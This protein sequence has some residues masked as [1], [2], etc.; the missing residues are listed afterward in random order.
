MFDLAIFTALGWERQ[1]VTQALFALEPGPEPGTWRGRLGDGASCVVAQTGMG[2][3][4]ARTAAAALPPAR[5]FLACGCA[6]GLAEWLQAGDLVVAEHVDVVDAEGGT[7]GRLDAHGGALTSWAAGRG[8]RTHQGAVV[9]TLTA[10]HTAD[11][12]N[13][14]GAAGALVVEMES[15]AVAAEARGRGI[16]FVGLRVVL[17]HAGQ[18]LPLP[19]GVVD[20][21]TGD[22]RAGRAVAA[23][24]LRPWL[25]P[26]LGRL[27]RQQRVADRKLRAFMAALL[28]EGGMDALLASAVPA[29]AAGGAKEAL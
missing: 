10:L 26:V 23:L 2:R 8:F 21:G 16:P 13:A 9:S 4:R 5:I 17:D 11:A 1:A 20:E 18:A 28:R 12:K 29:A 3:E 22:V 14:A 7:A 19:V 15:A 27:A 25:W 6:G 24:A